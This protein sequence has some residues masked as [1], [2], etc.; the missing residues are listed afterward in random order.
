MRVLYD[1]Q[2]DLRLRVRREERTC[3][4]SPAKVF[5]CAGTETTS[6][7]QSS[8]AKMGVEAATQQLGGSN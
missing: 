1:L 8:E 3:V 6:E 5:I 4:G 7:Q 2:A